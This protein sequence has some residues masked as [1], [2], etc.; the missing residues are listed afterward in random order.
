[1]KRIV[2]LLLVLLL[3]DAAAES[4]SMTATEFQ[5]D[6][7]SLLLTLS[8]LDPS[9]RIVE[10]KIFSIDSEYTLSGT[11][12]LVNQ[13]QDLTTELIDNRKP[14]V[15]GMASVTLFLK[16]PL[17]GKA[18]YVVFVVLDD[19]TT[20][21]TRIDPKAQIK[22][23]DMRTANHEIK[24]ESPI[25]LGL[26]PGDTI[27]LQRSRAYVD[28]ATESAVSKPVPYNGS[29]SFIENDGVFLKLDNTLPSGQVSSISAVGLSMPAEGKIDLSGAPKN[30]TDAYIVAKASAVAAV[31]QAPVFTLTGSVAPFH[32]AL[33]SIYLGAVRFDPSVNFDVGLR[34]TKTANSIVVPA[35]LSNV[36]IR[37]LPKAGF[38]GGDFRDKTVVSPTGLLLAY[39]PRYETDR[40][41][42]RVNLLGEVRTELY[43]SGLSRGVD[44]LRAR[45]SAKSPKYRDFIEGPIAG[46]QITPYFQLDAGAHVNNETVS[47]STAHQS[48][49]IP[50]HSIVRVYGGI[51][52]KIQ[53]GLFQVASDVSVIDLLTHEQV[54]YS[55]KQGVAIR[56][57]TGVHPH[58]KTDFTLFVDK[59]H[60]FGLS[61]TW[62]NG[63]SAPNFEYLNTANAG[64][65]VIY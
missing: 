38:G 45:A 65:K 49:V 29:V 34:S 60:H 2:L 32:P 41:F 59:A 5:L 15:T 18:T 51:S 22:V 62:E 23:F 64:I 37:G 58:S 7:L 33:K 43:L 48:E 36:F 12:Q 28:A 3:G 20:L 50:E 52:S 11:G 27:K 21:S 46:F 19:K 53:L 26:K 44:A 56:R 47:N 25:Y 10:Y 55:T 6:P 57:L 13:S 8:G 4:A 16:K 40:T 61:L 63:R 14:P 30:E 54:G 42:K 17:S 9:R 35:F 39:G 24:I 1:M 31:H